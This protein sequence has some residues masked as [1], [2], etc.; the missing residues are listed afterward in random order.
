MQNRRK[1][2]KVAGA[3]T[4]LLTLTGGAIS[5][6]VQGK[7]KKLTIL[8]TNDTHSRLDPFP[9]DHPKFANMG[10]MAK[11]AKVVGD[12]RKTEENV[13]LFDAGDIFQGTPYFNFYGGELNFKLMSMLK[14]DAATLGNH[15]LD[16]GIEG[17]EK[18][19]KHAKFPFVNCNYDF[20]DSSLTEKIEP[21]KIFEKSG[22]KV[23]VIG[24]GVELEG[25]VDPRN[26][27]K[28]KYNDPIKRANKFAKLLKEEKQC[29]LVIVLSHLGYKYENDLVSDVVVAE[30]SENIDL[31]IGGHTHTFM[32][33]P[34][35]IKNKAGKDTLV[36]QAGFGGINVG[37]IDFYFDKEK[38]TTIAK[39]EFIEIKDDLVKGLKGQKY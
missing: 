24:V 7:S 6:N 12:I 26:F 16:N 28:I 35:L 23:G 2:I 30:N 27:E 21:Y 38:N 14:Y 31:I 39:N 4:A 1:F 20:T 37:R 19:L 8:H 22:I 13:L 36:T 29:D 9:A 18:H 32:T 3:S 5:A 17:F 25:L 15:D 10:G 11:R 33:E 34:D